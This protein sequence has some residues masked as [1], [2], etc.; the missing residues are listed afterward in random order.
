MEIRFSAE[1]L[2]EVK[3]IIERYP[4]GRQKLALLPVLHIDQAV[5][6]NWLSREGMDYVAELLEVKLFEEYE[7][8]SVHT[9][10]NMQHVVNNVLATGRNGTA[11]LG[12]SGIGLE[13][14]RGGR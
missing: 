7:V 3:Q 9:I 11:A 14:G 4:E 8:A 13:R 10:L 1:R 2:A 6:D 5:L 12:E